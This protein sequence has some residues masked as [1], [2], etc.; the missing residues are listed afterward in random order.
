[1]KWKVPDQE[2]DQRLAN[3]YVNREDAM[4]RS[5]WRKLIKDVDDQDKCE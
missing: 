4:D 5:I 3:T 2:A 1:M